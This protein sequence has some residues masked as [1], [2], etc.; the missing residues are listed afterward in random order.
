[1]GKVDV[2]LTSPVVTRASVSFR[3]DI[4]AAE[5]LRELQPITGIEVPDMKVTI[6]YSG[7]GGND[8][9]NGNTLTITQENAKNGGCVFAP[10]EPSVVAVSIEVEDTNPDSLVNRMTDTSLRPSYEMPDDVY[11]KRTNSVRQWKRENMLGEFDPERTARIQGILESE[12]LKCEQLRVNER[13]SVRVPG[14][15]E[16]RGWLRFIGEVP[17]TKTKNLW[18]GVEYDRPVGTN[19]GTFAG[20]NFFGP[21]RDNYGSF[22]KPEYVETGAQ[23]TPLVDDSDEI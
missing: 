4:D 21:L 9:G 8:N 3:D 22:V 6:R 15:P 7:G 11:D 23:F 10:K 13:C 12:K 1:M 17:Q 2:H 18:C 20:T 19:N 5:L 14:K 16:R